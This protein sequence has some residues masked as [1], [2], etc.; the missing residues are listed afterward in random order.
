[1]APGILAASEAQ[2]SPSSPRGVVPK[3]VFPENSD[4]AEYARSLDASDPL[5]S[6]RSKFHIPSKVAL[7]ATSLSQQTD[8]HGNAAAT[9]AAE[10]QQ[11]EEGI[12]FCGNSLG[13]QPRATSRYLQAQLE[14]WSSINVYGHFREMDNSPLPAPWQSLAEAAAEQSSRIVGALKEEVAIANTLSVNLHLLMA[15][16]YRPTPKRNKILLEW[17][18][19]PSDH[20][21]IES[22]ISWHGYSPSEAMILVSPDSDHTISTEKILATIDAHAHEIAL[23]LLPGVQYYSGQFLD[24][25]RITEH[26]H[27]KGL[28]IGWDLAHAAGN[29]PLKLHDWNVDFAA[30]CTYKYMNAGPGAIAGLFVHERH[31]KVEYPDGPDAKPVFRH[32][33]TGWYGGDK[34]SRFQMDNNFRPI[35]GAGGFQISNPSAIDLASLCASLSVFNETSIEQLRE[36]SLKLT[37]YLQY[38]LLK[39]DSTPPSDDAERPFR[40]ITPLD[41]ARRGAQLSVLL[42]PGRLEKVSDALQAAGIVADQRKPDVIRVAPVPLYNTFYDVWQ[43]VQVLKKAVNA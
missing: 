15:S 30:W 1:M 16:F 20:Y 39:D 34:A 17:K 9:A 3:H 41:P 8:D 21:A 14:T 22:Q 10:Q 29:V 32:R 28:T 31:G 13:L 24:I 36:K 40:I 6:F 38:L 43:F 11:R 4:S 27:S 12:Y 2:T 19:F 25:G 26:A 5:R 35:P 33:L 18:A 37:A 7:K 23:V 42:Q